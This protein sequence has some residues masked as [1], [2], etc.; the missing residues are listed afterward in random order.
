[1]NPA[2]LTLKNNRTALVLYGLLMLM[3]V[4]TFLTIGRL[5]CPE[6]TIRNAQIITAYPGR[7]TVQVE[8]E[9]T[10][11]LEQAIR[12][13]PEVNEVS[14]T[15]KPGVSILSV[16]IKE[17]FFELE[18][19]WTD[20]RNKVTEAKLP[21]GAQKPVV[22]DDFGD[23]F[24]YVYA[25]RGG[26]FT[27]GELADYAEDIRDRLLALDGVA[28]VDFHGEQEERIYLEFSSSEMAAQ[29][30]SLPAVVKSLSDQNAVVSSGSVVVGQ[31]RLGIVAQGEFGSM[32]ELAAYQVQATRDGPSLRVSDLFDVKR[33]LADPATSLSHFNGERVLCIAVS[34]TKGGVVTE[35]GQRIEAELEKVRGD[36][37]V[38]LEI[39]TMFYQPKYVAKSIDNFL[40][41][42]GQAFFFVV[43]V[44][45]LFAGWRLAMIVGLL[46]PSTTLLCFV[47]MPAM[48]VVLE[49]MSIAALIIALGLLVDNAVVVSEQVLVR[50]GA[51]ES[52]RDAVVGAVKNLQIPLLAAS[53]T[54]IAAF[55]TIA[56]APGSTSEFTYSLFAVVSLALL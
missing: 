5:E 18:D 30:I 51:G 25:L 7:T 4:T 56:L 36:L 55:S 16:E 44:M 54:T 26:G 17:E 28:K 47:F 42:L 10:E 9:V 11:V 12:Q 48:G 15:S 23:V 46:V 14:S 20:M 19:I 8:E 21:E 45:L 31:E 40:V 34:M 27:E 38:G 41:N 39:E 33:G 2:S 3:G 52:R 22:Y 37:P 24:P 13:M 43:V 49:M 50:L 53:G 1:M 35:I 6:F 32:E 29:E